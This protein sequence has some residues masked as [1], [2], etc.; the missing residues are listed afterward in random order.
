M[1]ILSI[2]HASFPQICRTDIRMNNS[3]T[4]YT[5]TCQ[6]DQECYNEE[7][8]YEAQCTNVDG[9]VCVTCCDTDLC[10]DVSSSL[11]IAI[12]EGLVL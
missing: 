5:L 2:N 11:Y 10:N 3:E 7:G 1:G 12:E 8:I 9:S 4:S 6:Q